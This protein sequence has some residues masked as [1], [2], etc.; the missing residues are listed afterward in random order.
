MAAPGQIEYAYATL[1]GADGETQGKVRVMHNNCQ[2]GLRSHYDGRNRA[3]KKLLIARYRG[4]VPDLNS[5]L[6]EAAHTQCPIIQ[7]ERETR[8]AA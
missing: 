7:A 2:L 5:A 6:E 1:E 4:P 3:Q 8:K